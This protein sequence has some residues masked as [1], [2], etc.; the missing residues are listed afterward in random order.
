MS[1]TS[2][3]DS[4]QA[5]L[6]DT[7]PRDVLHREELLVVRRVLPPLR[8]QI[9][10]VAFETAVRAVQLVLLQQKQPDLVQRNTLGV[11]RVDSTLEGAQG[12]LIGSASEV[13]CPPTS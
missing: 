4:R 10:Q 11:T 9:L 8:V 12:S 13:P 3:R 1:G 2:E 7:V 5:Q 6:T